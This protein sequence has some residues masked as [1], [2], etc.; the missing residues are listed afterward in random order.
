VLFWRYCPFF[1]YINDY[2]HLYKVLDLN[3]VLSGR[4]STRK[5]VIYCIV[6]VGNHFAEFGL[7][8]ADSSDNVHRAAV[9][10]C[11]I[12]ENGLQLRHRSAF[13]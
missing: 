3:I 4:L 10:V 7:L 6:L 2:S 13:K 1:V 9:S 11:A 5:Y 12:G 8:A